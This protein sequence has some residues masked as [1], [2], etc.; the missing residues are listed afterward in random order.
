MHGHVPTGPR[1][2]I[3]TH[4]YFAIINLLFS[5]SA[6]LSRMRAIKLSVTVIVSVIVCVSVAFLAQLSATSA[7]LSTCLVYNFRLFCV[8]V[9]DINRQACTS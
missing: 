9:Q 1:H 2:L 8:L 4:R 3:P 5:Y 7:S 6:I